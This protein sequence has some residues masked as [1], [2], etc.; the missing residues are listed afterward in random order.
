MILCDLVLVCRVLWGGKRSLN[1]VL[2]EEILRHNFIPLRM[3]KI[4]CGLKQ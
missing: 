2:V 1:V 4:L 3:S